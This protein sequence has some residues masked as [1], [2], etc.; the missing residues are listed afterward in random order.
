[1]G[2]YCLR[3]ARLTCFMLPVAAALDAVS[4]DPSGAMLNALNAMRTS[5][6][7][8][9]IASSVPDPLGID[10]AISNSS[11]AHCLVPNPFGG[12]LC[13]AGANYSVA[14]QDIKGLRALHVT[15]FT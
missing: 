11:V 3:M 14:F 12:C 15:N 13:L 6:I 2:L 10:M 4:D 1:M 8:P 5:T 9:A 7:N